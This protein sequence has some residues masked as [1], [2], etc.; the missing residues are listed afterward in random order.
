[1]LVNLAYLISI[2]LT[3][4]PHSTTCFDFLQCSAGSAAVCQSLT[5][6]A[7]Q[8]NAFW[9]VGCPG[10][11]AGVLSA[12]CPVLFYLPPRF[13][14]GLKRPS[15]YRSTPFDRILPFQTFESLTSLIPLRASNGLQSHTLIQTESL[16]YGCLNTDYIQSSVVIPKH[17]LRYLIKSTLYSRHIFLNFQLDQYIPKPKRKHGSYT[18][19]TVAV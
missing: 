13:D 5:C 6:G 7:L 9:P 1:M 11:Y 8:N 12:D 16:G 15:K 10:G 18:T 4:S 19:A 17:L 3:I 2:F 14:T